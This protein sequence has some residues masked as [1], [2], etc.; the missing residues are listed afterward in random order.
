MWPQA[1][2]E[3]ERQNRSILKRIRIAQAERRDWKED[4]QTYLLMYR[5]TPHSVTGVSPAQL[6][7][8]REIRT[9]LPTL[10]EHN[11]S[12]TEIRDRDHERKGKGKIYSDNRRNAKESDV[13][14]GDFV[15]LKQKREDKFSTNFNPN[16]MQIV[17]KD[18]NSVL[19]ESQ[20]GA[21]Y[22][23]NTTHVKKFN[24]PSQN[25]SNEN[26]PSQNVSNSDVSS[27]NVL[28]QDASDQV[29]LEKGSCEK[30]SEMPGFSADEAPHKSVNPEISVSSRPVRE[31]KRPERFKD[32]IV[33]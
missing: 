4:L 15:L 18:G 11:I 13:N 14:V 20:E 21:K 17:R 29:V 33:G 26:V 7:F 6:L 16:P 22:R 2:G 9:K 8:G 30:A 27:Q 25:V 23:R 28:S 24:V 31:R 19:V 3:I 32:F 12:D 1:N 10:Q 5:S